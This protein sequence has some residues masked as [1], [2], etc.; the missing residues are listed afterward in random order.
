MCM[1]GFDTDHFDSSRFVVSCPACTPRD[2]P[3]YPLPAVRLISGSSRPLAQQVYDWPP[4]HPLACDEY[5]HAPRS[6]TIFPLRI[7]S[8]H[9]Q[10]IQRRQHP[11]IREHQLLRPI[12]FETNMKRAIDRSGISQVIL[13]RRF[14]IGTYDPCPRGPGQRRKASRCRIWAYR[15]DSSWKALM[16]KKLV[17][18]R[19]KAM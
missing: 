12:E 9:V 10:K 15:Q 5:V 1:T 13:V 2:R 16:G 11:H 3:S 14:W 4:T 8:R 6:K 7:A 18:D 19:N 17:C